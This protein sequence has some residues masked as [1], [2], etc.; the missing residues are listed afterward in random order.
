MGGAHYLTS[1][2]HPPPNMDTQARV[3][4]LSSSRAAGQERLA[5]LQSNGAA[6]SQRSA[7]VQRRA[8]E[9]IQRSTG[10]SGG[11]AGGTARSLSP[12]RTRTTAATAAVRGRSRSPVRAAP[13]YTSSSAYAGTAFGAPRAPSRSP[14]RQQYT[15][16]PGSPQQ[17]YMQ[18]PGS[19]QRQ[20]YYG[21][22]VTT[23]VPSAERYGSPQYDP[24]YG[25]PQYDSNDLPDRLPQQQQQL[26]AAGATAASLADHVAAATPPRPAG[27][28]DT[29]ADTDA[30]TRVTEGPDPLASAMTPEERHVASGAYNEDKYSEYQ[31]Q[32]WTG[33][34]RSIGFVT[35]RTH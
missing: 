19:P 34:H 4:Q 33:E 23:D 15:Q 9:A 28:A 31:R 24:Q 18:H 7:D 14:P 13:A 21:T 16:H 32:V 27:A 2:H 10:L 20:Q 8:L 29:D 1:P 3:A 22:Q 30:A 25:S 6:L 35:E 17:Q 26:Q 11:G 5:Q 12:P